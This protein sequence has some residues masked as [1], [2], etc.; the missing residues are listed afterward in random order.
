MVELGMVAPLRCGVDGALSVKHAYDASV[1]SSNFHP[2]V[3]AVQ[4]PAATVTTER[5]DPARPTAVSAWPDGAGRPRSATIVIR[6]RDG[7]IIGS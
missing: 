6:K 2:A 1:T 5:S 4:H 7:G 3:I